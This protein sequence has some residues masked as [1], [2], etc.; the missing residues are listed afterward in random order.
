M[1][2]AHI[3]QGT[4]LLQGTLFKKSPSGP[5][6]QER[7]FQ[8]AGGALVNTQASKNG[9]GSIP[10]R[11]VT[12]VDITQPNLYEF[13]VS[14]RDREFRFRAVTKAELDSWVGTIT[15]EAR[16]AAFTDSTSPT[17]TFVHTFA[18]AA[19]PRRGS[20]PTGTGAPPARGIDSYLASRMAVPQ[21]ARRGSANTPANLGARMMRLSQK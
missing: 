17:S 20:A 11:S 16:Q 8:I 6:Y 12:K 3:Y 4:P 7:H 13:S 19:P 21:A 2:Q 9:T 1:S 15:K 10:L 14:T 18:A 5:F